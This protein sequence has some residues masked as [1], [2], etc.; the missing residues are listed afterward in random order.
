M[1]RMPKGEIEFLLFLELLLLDVGQD[2][3]DKAA[4]VGSGKRRP[5]DVQKAPINAYYGRSP[6]RKV[7]VRCIPF[8]R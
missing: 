5:L 3:I 6:D 7:Q 8:N 4:G 1:M 2:T